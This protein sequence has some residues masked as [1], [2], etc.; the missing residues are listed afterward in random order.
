MACV[1]I[2]KMVGQNLRKPC[3]AQ[4]FWWQLAFL[5]KS[6]NA[7]KY[8]WL[9]IT[10]EVVA[11]NVIHNS[12]ILKRGS[13]LELGNVWTHP[14]KK[15]PQ[16]AMNFG[17]WKNHKNIRMMNSTNT[18]CH[19]SRFGKTKDIFR[20]RT[21]RSWFGTWISWLFILPRAARFSPITFFTFIIHSRSW[22]QAKN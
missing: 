5:F 21:S 18:L 12:S 16:P 10:F 9:L 1:C 6:S 13:I 17:F 7:S 8:Q 11:K 20:W 15:S 4:F 2:I 19:L 14:L 3:S 22:S